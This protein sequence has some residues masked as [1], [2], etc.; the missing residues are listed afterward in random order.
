NLAQKVKLKGFTIVPLEL[1]LENGRAKLN[2]ALAKGKALYD[3]RQNLKE[4]DA[5]REIA[6]N[7]KNYY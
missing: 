6:K 7:I 4:K 3:K 1:Y 2:I 5:Q